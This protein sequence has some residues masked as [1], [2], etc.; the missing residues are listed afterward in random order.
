MWCDRGTATTNTH[1]PLME[2]CGGHAGD[3]GSLGES[4]DKR[5]DDVLGF[6]MCQ[7]PGRA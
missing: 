1:M 2:R 4:D 5:L 6:N 3:G 7:V